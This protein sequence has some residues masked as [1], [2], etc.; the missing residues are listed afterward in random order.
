MPMMGMKCE[1]EDGM[2]FAYAALSLDARAPRGDGQPTNI[3]DRGIIRLGTVGERK[4]P[5]KHDISRADVRID[6]CMYIYIYIHVY[7]NIHIHIYIY[8]F[9]FIFIHIHIYIYI[10]TNVYIYI[11]IYKCV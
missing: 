6:T 4:Q 7:I 5:A 9:I 10:Y 8:I 1:H 3:N 2:K 11:Y